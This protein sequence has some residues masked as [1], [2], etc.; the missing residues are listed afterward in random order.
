MDNFVVL[1]ATE[2]DKVSGGYFPVSPDSPLYKWYKII[3]SMG[4][5]L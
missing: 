5:C 1:N 4:G 3:I 2:L